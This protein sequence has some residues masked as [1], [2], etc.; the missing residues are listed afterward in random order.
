M[1]A[2][3]SVHPCSARF[4]RHAGRILGRR[5]IVCGRGAKRQR[6]K[7]HASALA[8]HFRKWARVAQNE[9]CPMTLPR[10]NLAR[11]K[12]I[13]Q[14]VGATGR[15]LNFL[16]PGSG[17][18]KPSCPKF[19]MRPSN[20]LPYRAATAMTQRGQVACPLPGSTLAPSRNAG[21]LRLSFAAV[22]LCT[23]PPL[24]SGGKVGPVVR[25]MLCDFTFC[26]GRATCG[27]FR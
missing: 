22:T 5:A 27:N 13:G 20:D 8:C 17:F 4:L 12:V 21:A 1:S 16:W 19:S 11:E 26:R 2:R 18:G 7:A 9:E 25:P 24:G 6:W 3:H 15:L 14:A 23:V 10:K